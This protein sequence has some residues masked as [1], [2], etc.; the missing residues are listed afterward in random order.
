MRK[1]TYTQF[2]KHVGIYLEDAARDAESY[3]VNIPGVGNVVLITAEDFEI[4]SDAFAEL[5]SKAGEQK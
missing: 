1:L 4:L 5:H 3:T 2:L